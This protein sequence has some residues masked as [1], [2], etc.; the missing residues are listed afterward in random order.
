MIELTNE[1]LYLQFTDDC[2]LLFT[3]SNSIKDLLIEESNIEAEQNTLPD[4][5]P[6]YIDIT[7]YPYKISYDNYWLWYIIENNIYMAL[8]F[9]YYNFTV[10]F[11]VENY[12]TVRVFYDNGYIVEYG[13][14]ELFYKN[15]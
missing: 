9:E 12:V 6:E 2:I 1:F 15:I 11:D 8:S 14:L 13:N 5:L 3:E 10:Q 4:E 7:S